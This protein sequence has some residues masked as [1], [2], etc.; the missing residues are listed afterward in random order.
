M[1]TTSSDTPLSSDTFIGRQVELDS[2]CEA[3]TEVRAGR[4]RLFLLCGEPGIGKTT[5]ADEV[6]RR[7]GEAGFLTLWGRCWK[8]EGAPAYW[9]WVQL[10][11]ACM[12]SPLATVLDNLSDVAG[13]LA[14][15]VPELGAAGA[16]T[17]A[18]GSATPE[19][20]RFRLFDSVTSFFRAAG[21]EQP[22][23]LLLDDLQWADEA[24]L[25]LLQF[26]ARELR[27]TAIL[28]VATYREGEVRLS[29]TV[30]PLLAAI[31]REGRT[32]LLGGLSRDEVVDMV[33]RRVELTPPPALLA[34]IQRVTEGNP[35][36]VEEVLQLLHAQPRL[37]WSSGSL[38]VPE[39]VRDVIRRRLDAL[40]EETRHLLA[41]AA[42][43]GREF[44]LAVVQRTAHTN[45][46]SDG[47]IAEAV[48]AGVLVAA[49]QPPNRYRF[50]HALIGE[51]LYE[52]LPFAQRVELHRHAAAALLERAGAEIESHLVELAH[53]F[54][55]A[56]PGGDVEAAVDWATRAGDHDISH[57]AF[58]SGA[59]LYSRALE[60]MRDAAPPEV[61]AGKW[62]RR[63]IDLQL[64]FGNAC[65][66]FNDLN[67]ADA[68]FRDAAA[69]AK[70]LAN[71]DLFAR[72]VLALGAARFERGGSDHDLVALLREA[73][74]L[75]GNGSPALR[76][77]LLSRL[78]IS[79][80]LRGPDRRQLEATR[81]AVDLARAC[82]DRGALAMALHARHSLSWQ[83]DGVA[84]RL[85]LANEIVRVAEE[86]KEEEA[87]LDGLGWKIFDLLEIGDI[88]AAEAAIA[89]YEARAEAARLPRQRWY[90]CVHRTM[91]ALLRGDFNEAER[92]AQKGL[93]I[94]QADG[95]PPS[96]FYAAQL[97]TIRREQGRMRELG[98]AVQ[99]VAQQY[100]AL[101]AWQAAIA[102]YHVSVGEEDEA[103]AA[104][105]RISASNYA[106]LAIDV[107]WLATMSMLAETCAAL[108]DTVR[109]ELLYALLQPYAGRNVVVVGSVTVRGA[110]DYFLGLL[111]ATLGRNDL[112]VQHFAAASDAHRRLGAR[113][114]LAF[115]QYEWGHAL[116]RQDP[117]SIKAATL[118][119]Q[120]L[121]MGHNFGLARLEQDSEP[122]V[123]QATGVP[124]FA[125][126]GDH[127]I[128][129]FEG[130]I[131]R[132][133]D[134]RGCDYIGQLLGRPGTTLDAT[135]LVQA[136]GG[137]SPTDEQARVAVRK[138]ISVVLR[139]L[140][141]QHPALAAHLEE[142]LR[143][144]RQCVYQPPAPPS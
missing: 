3:F 2:V 61:D 80:Y 25:L 110:V 132:L 133:K 135:S 57:L 106:D 96:Q 142:S 30:A 88:T 116:R 58:E 56:A 134:S 38:K 81:E 86:A 37:D 36:F 6:G 15:V 40:P 108:G 126:D 20:E 109:A 31:S 62:K 124:R 89:S 90:A 17:A 52:D 76:S 34:E 13:D 144:G 28:I 103:R 45:G 137:G 68:A 99:A 51:T 82:G 93:A 54:L 27:G 41:A 130:K 140:K 29:P 66:H 14:R 65:M 113:P 8:G 94:R 10:I 44:D 22:L 119:D 83:H 70:A 42:V 43:V 48:D 18:I 120:A 97:F 74:D 122:E 138:A 141:A 59:R 95:A 125:K 49:G 71:Y 129:A 33:A 143:T 84:E 127:W 21:G 118:I 101:P 131:L 123:E 104:F 91:H 136:A 72:A 73:L 79:S 19:Q 87:A 78:A 24:S 63:R 23:M 11:R 4:G 128:A 100:A 77:R 112:A 121:A 114:L 53:H 102:L 39:G 50:S 7:A 92:L 98:P 5:L 115:S 107:T 60:L 47:R 111:A 67:G 1:S 85:D 46:G 55:G 105:E 75:L 9:P 12:R 32:L 16:A 35:L 26:I 139:T 117:T 69:G 64:R